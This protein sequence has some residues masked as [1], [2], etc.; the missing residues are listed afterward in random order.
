M[1]N[2]H[3]FVKC[4]IFA[5]IQVPHQF[6]SHSVP[7]LI[8]KVKSHTSSWIIFEWRLAI[9]LHVAFFGWAW[10]V[11]RSLLSYF[12]PQLHL[13]LLVLFILELFQDLRQGNTELGWPR[14]SP[15]PTIS[16]NSGCRNQDGPTLAEVQD[17][18]ALAEIQDGPAPSE[19]QS[20]PV[21]SETHAWFRL[22]Y[23]SKWFKSFGRLYNFYIY[24]II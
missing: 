12:S 19:V 6:K 5:V 21:P 22:L 10:L 4:N 13:S 9:R 18:P 2:I 1:V 23:E 8:F 16:S 3:T 17:G 7:D 24:S 11:Y 15:A 20:G 14:K